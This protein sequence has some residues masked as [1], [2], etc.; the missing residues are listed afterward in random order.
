MEDSMS[1]GGREGDSAVED[2]LSG[3]M[4]RMLLLSSVAAQ[5]AHIHQ[6]LDGQHQQHNL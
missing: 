4:E 5:L 6:L 3:G 2:S 1:A